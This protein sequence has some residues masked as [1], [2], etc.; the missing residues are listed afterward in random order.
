MRERVLLDDDAGKQ[1]GNLFRDEVHDR[2]QASLPG[3]AGDRFVDRGCL[4][5]AGLD[6]FDA[7][8]ASAQLLQCHFVP[9]QA[10]LLQCQG[11]SR[12]TL[13]TECADADHSSLEIG[14]RFHSR[15]GEE[16]E[17][18]H[19]AQGCNQSQIAPA[20]VD[21]RNRGQADVHDI[22][23]PGLQLPRAPASAAHVDDIDLESLIGVEA[24]LPRHPQCK[25]RVDRLRDPELERGEIR[26]GHGGRLRSE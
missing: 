4:D 25:N 12:V 7:P 18:D 13:R 11:H 17:S 8:H 9:R 22:D 20:P 16:G 24:R 21:P 15:R 14:R 26:C 3:Q 6:R 5:F 23:A 1:P 2:V 19:V 10:E